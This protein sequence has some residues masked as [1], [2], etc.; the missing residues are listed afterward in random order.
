MKKNNTIKE[1]QIHNCRKQKQKCGGIENI[2]VENAEQARWTPTV[3]GAHTAINPQ[4]LL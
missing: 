4:K 1:E 2:N 3:L